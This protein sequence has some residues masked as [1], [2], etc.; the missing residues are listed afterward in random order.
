MR[1]HWLLFPLAATLLLT[2]C[3]EDSGENNANTQFMPGFTP[4]APGSNQLQL[5]TPILR[6]IPAGADVTYCTYLE[7]KTPK[8]LDILQYKGFQSKAGSHHTILYAVQNE[9]PA[10]THECNETDMLNARYL[11]GGGADA[12]PQDIPEGIVLRMKANSQLLIQTHWI[13]ASTEA[14]DGQAAFNLDIDD[15]D[16]TRTPEQLFTLAMTSIS[17]EPHQKT[18]TTAS[19]VVQQDMNWILLGGH[20]HELGTHVSFF[21]TP[22]GGTE[23]MI[24]DTPWISEYQ[25]NPPRTFFTKDGAMKVHKGD[26]LRVQCDFNNT[27]ADVV[28][29]P[30]EMCVGW[31]YFYPGENEIDCTDG[32]WG[33]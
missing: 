11:A 26:T 17:I 21:L 15:V 18:T 20:Q 25:F 9:R 30:R 27:T 2:G 31:S 8:D 29:F 32:Q 33:N 16:L 22:A 1:I 10:G 14:I 6:D 7:Y 19:C 12:P 24:Y 5:S 28:G 3:T 23:T 13:N 4:D